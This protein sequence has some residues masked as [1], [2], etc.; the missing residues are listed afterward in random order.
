MSPVI[1]AL[2]PFDSINTL[3]DPAWTQSADARRQLG[4]GVD[5]H[6]ETT[7]DDRSHRVLVD[8]R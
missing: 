6:G 3:T 2:S 4:V 8:V 7:V 1:T 5:E